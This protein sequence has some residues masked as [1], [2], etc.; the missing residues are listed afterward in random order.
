M[1]KLT[2][3]FRNEAEEL[4][5]RRAERDQVSHSEVL[6]N[7]LSLYDFIVEDGRPIGFLGDDGE[8]QGRIRYRFDDSA[9]DCTISPEYYR[10]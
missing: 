5:R 9:K 10:N 4:L 3:E 7:A 1:S 8:A 2:I 6:R